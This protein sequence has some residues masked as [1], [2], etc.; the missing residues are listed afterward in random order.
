MRL[1]VLETGHR[2]IQK[3]F[4]AMA[5]RVVRG[6]VPGPIL[7]MSYRS[8]F[9]GKKLAACF[10][11]GMRKGTEWQLGEVELFAAFVSQLNRCR[12]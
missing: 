6:N 8:E 9:C 2:P 3:L 5:K 12:Y 7:T 10:Q 11:D 4:F 1:S